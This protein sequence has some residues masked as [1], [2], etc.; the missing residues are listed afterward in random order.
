MKL[1]GPIV[2][3]PMVVENAPE[4]RM[5]GEEGGLMGAFMR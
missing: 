2:D 4:E 3:L 1:L 5:Q